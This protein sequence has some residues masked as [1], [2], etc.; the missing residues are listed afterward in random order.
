MRPNED[1]EGASG[2]GLAAAAANLAELDEEA[3]IAAAI[4]AS[5]ENVV[6][7]DNKVD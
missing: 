5:L 4:K 1:S 2:S 3:Q 6:A 7:G